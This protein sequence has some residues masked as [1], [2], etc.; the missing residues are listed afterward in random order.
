MGFVASIQSC[1]SSY[2]TFSGRAS[3]SE[4]WWFQVFMFLAGAALVFTGPGVFLAVAVILPAWAVGTRRLHDI[5]KS[6]WNFLWYVIPV[7]GLILFLIWNT[8]KG[9]DG[10][11]DYG[12]DPLRDAAPSPGM[13]NISAVADKAEQLAKIKVLLESGTINQGEFDRMK[14]EL[15]GS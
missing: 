13:R 1:F 15:L 12:E 3:R 5:G 8:R 10:A 6:G 9:T 7:L 14:A 11:N 4:F 2:A